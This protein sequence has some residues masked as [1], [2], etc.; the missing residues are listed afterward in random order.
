MPR[1]VDPAHPS[2]LAG[3]VNAEILSKAR[4]SAVVETVDTPVVASAE[5]KRDD[6]RECV[7]NAYDAWKC[8]ACIKRAESNI[9]TS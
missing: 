7:W 6:A 3:K 1:S 4:L 8:F 2:L 5:A 9:I